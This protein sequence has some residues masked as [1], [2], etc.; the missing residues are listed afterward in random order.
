MRN[1]DINITASKINNEIRNLLFI[2][3]VIDMNTINNEY[4]T[5]I[6]D[7]AHVFFSYKFVSNYD[8]NLCVNINHFNISKERTSNLIV[9]KFEY[10]DFLNKELKI[11]F[12]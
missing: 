1:I 10:F 3:H 8:E 12:D 11:V 5:I 2:Q 4:F 7:H 6:N 9:T